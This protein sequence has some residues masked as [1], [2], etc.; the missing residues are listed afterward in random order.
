VGMTNPGYALAPLIAATATII[1]IALVVQAGYRDRNSRIFLLVLACLGMWAIFTFAMRSS[2]TTEAALIWDRLIS[3]CVVGLFA[4]FFHFCHLYIGRRS[5]WPVYLLYAGFAFVFGTIIFT[6]LGVKAMTRAGFGFAPVLGRMAIPVF[7]AIQLLIIANFVRLL[8]A[9]RTEPSVDRR[10]RYLLL[11]VAGLLPIVGTVADG[12]TDLPPVGIWTNLGFCTVC[13]VAILRYRLFDLPVLARRGIVRLLVST[14]IAAPYVG[15]VLAVNALLRDREGLLFVY[16]GAMIVFAI[17]MW[18]AYEWSRR[19]VDRLFHS[20]RFDRQEELRSLARNADAIRGFPAAAS[21]ST[22]L[23]RRALGASATHLLQPVAGSTALHLVASN[24]EPSRSMKPILG[25]TSPIVDW[26]RRHPAVLTAKTLA[27]E[28]LLQNI[29]QGERL[30]LTELRATLLSPLITPHG[31]FAGIFIIGPKASRRPYSFEDIQLLDSLGGEAAMALENARLYHDAVR[32][33]ET[34]EAWLNSLPDAVVIVDKENIIRFLNAEGT[35]RFSATPGQRTF[36]NAEPLVEE[37]QPRR[38][39]ETILGLE[40]EIASA[41]LVDTDGQPCT[42]LVLRDMTARKEEQAQ[43][44]RLETKAR[45]A[46][47]L[48]SIGEMASGIAHEINNPLT[49]VIG[50]SQF[51]SER[52]LPQESREAVDQILKGSARVAA[53]VQRLLTFARQRKPQRALIDLNEVIRSTLAFRDYAL[54]IGN[55]RVTLD[56]DPRLPQTVADAQQMQQ[57]LLNLFMNAETAMKKAHGKGQ[58]LLTSE[59]RGGLIH[60]IVGDDG[61]GVPLEIQDRIF[62]PFFTTGEVGQGTGLGLS[63]CHGIMSD[64]GGRIWVQNRPGGGADFHL[65]LPVIS[66]EPP[67]TEAAAA[68]RE[69]GTPRTRALVLDDEPAV[70]ELLTR[71]LEKEGHLVDAVADGRT[72]IECISSRRYGLILLDIRL[73]GMSGIEVYQQAKG[74]AESIGA[75][76][77]FLTG[78]LMN[79]ETR[80]FLRRTGVP[81]VTKPFQTSDLIETIDKVLR[82]Q[83]QILPS[84]S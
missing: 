22:E 11:A 27:V 59:T 46:S 74:I 63:I 71:V 57:V 78:D 47:H 84:S 70:R 64:H 67:K 2:P 12:F 19:L 65:E 6:D 38:F 79:P 72:A 30:A 83:T 34:L 40:Y 14:L 9:R 52:Q 4:A 62:D 69:P 45:M 42:V 56:L 7:G 28:P 50:Y 43:R 5:R 54:R 16:T 68:I 36:L 41:P 26:L 3:V 75:R 18:P 73:P 35:R 60:I 48:A 61:L 37:A 81:I 39:T 80:D 13:S 82:K 15:A 33:R 25:A 77:I 23:V 76:V 10:R 8:L 29:A 44:H 66:G 58:L 17:V 55:I 53:I 20:E 24:G 1:L 32:A 49:V 31:G 21:R 51:L